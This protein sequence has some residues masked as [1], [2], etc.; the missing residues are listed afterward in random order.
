VPILV[1][2][3]N[4]SASKMGRWYTTQENAYAFLALGKILKKQTGRKYTGT[5]SIDGKLYTKFDVQNFNFSDK[6]WAGKKVT[7]EIQ[8]EGTCY[9]AWRVDGIPSKMS[10]DESDNDLMVRRHYLNEQGIPI[11]YSSFKQGD[12]VIAKITLKALAE[13]LDNVAVVDMLPAGLEIENPRLQ[14]RKGVDWIGKSAYQPMYLD[15]RDD[16]MILYGNFSQGREQTF[17][18]GLRAVTEGTFILP[19]IQ[20]EAMYAPMKAS[21]ASSGKVVVR[22]P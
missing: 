15:I 16:R 5:A 19:P 9:F 2:S 21:V 22:R 3:L 10:I 12:L 8:G 14:S 7:I 11:D 13:N 20:A 6:N 4:E 1:E 17:Y 18:Y